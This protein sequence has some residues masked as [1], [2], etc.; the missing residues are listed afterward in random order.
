M[1]RDP[2]LAI[3]EAIHRVQVDTHRSQLEE[4]RAIDGLRSDVA[5]VELKVEKLGATRVGQFL[6]ALEERPGAV[7]AGLG[8][9]GLSLLVLSVLLIFVLDHIDVGQ[10]V[11][12]KDALTGAKE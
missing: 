2:H 12:L 9:L 10:A 3:L 7:W 6:T 11:Q 5:R 1:S 8:V 4:A